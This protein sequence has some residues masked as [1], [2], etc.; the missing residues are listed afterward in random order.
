MSTCEN[1]LFWEGDKYT[2]HGICHRY[3]RLIPYKDLSY[4]PIADKDD[5]CGEFTSSGEREDEA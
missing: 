5:W 4:Y 3:P 2:E 1:C